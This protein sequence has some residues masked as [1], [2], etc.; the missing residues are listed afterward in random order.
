MR[1]IARGTIA[2]L[3]I[4]AMPFAGACADE[5]DDGATTDEEIED[6]RKGADEIEDEVNE[7]IEGQDK[8]SNSDGE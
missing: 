1:R 4:I 5:D 8:G 3:A 2:A 7:E 6:L